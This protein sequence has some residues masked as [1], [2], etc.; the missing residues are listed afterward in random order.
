MSGFNGAAADQ[1]RKWRQAHSE[2]A[3][4]RT[5]RFNGAAA[6]QPRKWAAQIILY[7]S[8]YRQASM[9]PRLISRGKSVAGRFERARRIRFNG[10][11]ADQPRKCMRLGGALPERSCASMG[12]RLISRGNVAAT[13]S[14]V[15]QSYP[16]SMGPR[17]ISRGKFVRIHC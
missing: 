8:R 5:K 1:P 7:V 15:R 6:D 9:G 10:A 12:P 3:G 11:A 17:L 2:S 14:A 13:G 4:H 16:A